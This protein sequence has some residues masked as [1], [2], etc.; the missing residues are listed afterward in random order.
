MIAVDYQV[1]VRK[2]VSVKIMWHCRLFTFCINK[3]SG[4]RGFL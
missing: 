4:K 2:I 1:A 3:I